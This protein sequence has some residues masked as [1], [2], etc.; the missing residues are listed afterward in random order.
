MTR[1]LRVTRLESSLAPAIGTWDG[2]GADNLWTTA[3]N[4]VGDVAP[5]PG[6]D[7]RMPVVRNLAMRVVFHLDPILLEG[8]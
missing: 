1:S 5:Q 6:D 2:G 3:A 8:I 4:W 7:L